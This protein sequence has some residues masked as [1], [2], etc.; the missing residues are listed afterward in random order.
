MISKFAPE[1]DINYTAFEKVGIEG[2]IIIA[3]GSGISGKT[4]AVNFF[5]QQFKALGCTII[6]VLDMKK[7]K[8]EMGFVAFE[9][10][11]QKH[12]KRLEE[13]GLTPRKYEIK[14]YHLLNDNI[15]KTKISET[16]FFTIP[17]KHL[18]DTLI[19]FILNNPDSEDS[20]DVIKSIIKKMKPSDSMGEFFYLLGKEVE[21]NKINKKHT[22]IFSKKSETFGLNI[23][24][25][26]RFHLKTIARAFA[27]FRN[28]GIVFTPLNYPL[29]LDFEKILNDHHSYHIFFDSYLRDEKI[30]FF[31]I[32]YTIQRLNEEI[33]ESKKPVVI[34]LEEVTDVFRPGN[35]DW[36]DVLNRKLTAIISNLRSQ[37]NGV[38]VIGTTQVWN[39]LDKSVRDIFS[40]PM[41][42]RTNS[43]GDKTMIAKIYGGEI[44]NRL[45]S[46]QTGQFIM[47]LPS[48]IPG[49]VPFK[50]VGIPVTRHS[51]PEPGM[52]FEKLWSKNYPKKVF[53]Y[54]KMISAFKKDTEEWAKNINRR[55]TKEVEKR[56]KHIEL[57]RKKREA[58][59]ERKQKTESQTMTLGS[60]ARQSKEEIKKLA[61][62]ECLNQY[63]EK[64]D[65]VWRPIALRLGVHPST[66]K[67]WFTDYQKEIKLRGES[68][69]FIYEE[70]GDEEKDEKVQSE[71]EVEL[72][73][74]KEV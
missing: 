71:K 51:H 42:G 7:T 73:E 26:E 36:R 10:K 69:K 44:G 40:Q 20:I 32:L 9:P 65:V 49:K 22:R 1:H 54:K 47:I 45:S 43:P 3:G 25:A 59:M 60:L 52:N 28:E 74:I 4:M 27:M 67:S 8:L 70:I 31:R 58:E 14:K 21:R 19:R 33:S 13:F 50:T 53:T 64:G 62:T 18:D 12:T 5:A 46:L 72:V 23:G 56:E 6:S 16:N 57:A 39:K 38:L 68:K 37:G 15:P 48:K 24:Q 2:H 63:E 17:I 30:K 41:L 11:N 66:L 61:I 29:N 34:I 55:I 35:N